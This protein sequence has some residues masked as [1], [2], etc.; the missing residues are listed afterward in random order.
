MSVRAPRLSKTVLN[1][2]SKCRKRNLNLHRHKSSKLFMTHLVDRNSITLQVVF[3]NYKIKSFKNQVFR[4]LAQ[5]FLLTEKTKD[6][7]PKGWLT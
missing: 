4:N 3:C 2:R 6:V 7:T 1:T 5:M